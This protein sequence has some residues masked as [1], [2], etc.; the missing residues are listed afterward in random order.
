MFKVQLFMSSVQHM[1]IITQKLMGDKI[2]PLVA[3]FDITFLTHY[4]LWY[5]SYECT[6][7]HISHQ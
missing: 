6:S 7:L 1:K 3:L 2:N 4:E 5:L